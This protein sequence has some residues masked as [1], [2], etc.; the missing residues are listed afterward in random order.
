MSRRENENTFSNETGSSS[1]P[2]TEELATLRAWLRPTDYLGESSE[3]KKHLNSH[4]PGTGEWLQQTKQY[5]QWHDEAKCGALWVKAIAGAGKSVLAARLISHLQETEEQTPVLFFFFRQIVAAN[6]DAQSF[7]RDWMSQLVGYSPHLRTQINTWTKQHR[8]SRTFSFDEL[9]QCV[10]ESLG[11]LD[12]VYCVVDAMDELNRDQTDFLLRRLVDLGQI[13]PRAV[14][15]VMTS[16][17]LPQIQKVLNTPSVLQLRLEDRQTNKDI[18]L[19]IEYR[20]RQAPGISDATKE[21]IRTSIE[22]RVHPSFLYARLMLNE[23]MDQHKKETIDRASV[24]NALVSLPASMETMYS[25]MLHD[26]SQVAGVPQ[27]RQLLILQL[28]T[29]ASRPLRLLEIATVLDF[30][31]KNEDR[32]RHGDTKNMTRISCGPLLEILE[33]E[34]VSI[35]HHSFTEFLID[36]ERTV[37]D[38]AFPVIDPHK[39]NE[40]MT[41]ICV[42]YLLSG[43]LS[44]W[45]FIDPAPFEEEGPPTDIYNKLD[46]QAQR[47]ALQLQYPFLAYALTGWYY[48]ARK[49]PDLSE[50]VQTILKSLVNSDNQTFLAWI[51]AV[52]QPPYARESLSPFHIASWAGMTSALTAMLIPGQDL[53]GWTG[54]GQNALIMAA[55]QGHADTVARL[56]QLGA[57]PNEPDDTGFNALHYAAGRDHHATVQVLINASV[58]PITPTTKIRPKP[59]PLNDESLAGGTPLGEASR[60]GCVE[61]IRVM[62]PHLAEDDRKRSLRAAVY[63][64]RG[65][66]IKYLV[67]AA[68]LDLKSDF[69][70]DLMLDAASKLDLETIELLFSRG[71]DP[72]FQR[73]S[74][75][76]KSDRHNPYHSRLPKPSSLLF[77]LCHGARYPSRKY[78]PPGTVDKAFDFVFNSGCDI[79]SRDERGW[80][81]LHYC[82]SN[83]I[84]MVEKLLDRGGDVHAKDNNGSAPLHLYTSSTGTEQILTALLKYGATWGAVRHSDGQT[85]LHA[86]LPYLGETY[87]IEY[88]LPILTHWNVSDSKGNTVLHSVI[89]GGKWPNDRLK[90]LLDILKENGVDIN[91][92]N[93]NGQT[94]LHLVSNYKNEDTGRILVA[95]G[96]DIEARDYKGRTWWLHVVTEGNVNETD[97]QPI[98]DLGA[99]PNAVDDAGNNAL[100]LVYGDYPLED[101]TVE[102]LLDA[103]VDPLHVNRRGETIYHL[104]MRQLFGHSDYEVERAVRPLHN[105]KTPIAARDYQ[106]RTLLHIAC[107]H[108]SSI[109]SSRFSP[110]DLLS[111]FS[112]PEIR[113]MIRAADNHGRYPV[114]FAAMSSEIM[115]V[116]LIE[117]GA[118]ILVQTYKGKSPLHKAAA[119]GQS[120]VVGLLLEAYLER[121]ASAEINRRDYI[122]RTPLQYACRSGRLES[123]RLLL[124][125]GADV[126]MVDDNGCTPLHICAEF[127]I[128]IPLKI[129]EALELQYRAT[130]TN[131][132]HVSDIIR[133]LC[134]QG[135]DVTALNKAGKTPLQ[136][137][138]DSRAD[139]MIITL[140]G[141]PNVSDQEH[142]GGPGIVLS[143]YVEFLAR[144]RPAVSVV[145]EMIEKQLLGHDLLRTCEQ[146]HKVRAYDV[147]EEIADR[148]FTLNKQD[149]WT[150]RFLDTLARQE[151]VCLSQ[152]LGHSGDSIDQPKQ[153]A[154]LPDKQYPDLESFRLTV[155]A[156]KIRERPSGHGIGLHDLANGAHWWQPAAIRYLAQHGADV[157]EMNA[158]R[159]TPL[160]VAVR[161]DYRCLETVQ[162]LLELGADTN[163]LKNDG[164]TPLNLAVGDTRITR[165][166]LQHGADFGAG[167][168]PVYY[169]AVCAGDEDLVRAI[170]ETG[171]DPNK[172]FREDIPATYE[173]GNEVPIRQSGTSDRSLRSRPLYRAAISGASLD[174]DDE[175]KS[176]TDGVIKVLLEYGA[177]PLMPLDG[178]TTIIHYCLCH[179]AHV[180]P[181]LTVPGLNLE[182]RDGYGRTMLLAACAHGD[183]DELFDIRPAPS[184]IRLVRK[185]CDMGAEL[186][187]ADGEGNTAA[188]LLIHRHG[189]WA[190]KRMA[191]LIVDIIE[192]CPSL[193]SQK[194]NKGFTPFHLAVQCQQT[195]LIQRLLALGANAAEPDPEE[196][197][198][199][200][201]AAE[202]MFKLGEDNLHQALSLGHTI[203]ARNSAGETPIMKYISLGNTEGIQIF[204]NLGADIFAT[205]NAGETL[206]HVLARAPTDV[207]KRIPF[208]WGLYRTDGEK[209]VECFK[210]LLGLGLDPSWE[211]RGSRTAMDVAAA[212]GNRGILG[213]FQ[214]KA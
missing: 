116:W 129:L 85:P 153:L 135:A 207:H 113:T 22:G 114:H 204:Q 200:H 49:L 72:N 101:E 110:D 195:D 126:N 70:G 121:R 31:N 194:N 212:Y 181:L 127:D 32:T 179:R 165:L 35:I 38:G 42:R 98:L 77:A 201:Y 163:I 183:S 146:L 82:V 39:T 188:H 211:D 132:L 149:G 27:E 65:A 13:R 176:Q 71:A 184:R 155:A 168:P 161:A 67:N 17:P 169:S 41:I 97:L 28:V 193:L 196:N 157:N 26:H 73:K 150:S 190:L 25:Q 198:M 111:V 12:R 143:P 159:G 57:S 59:S 44:S 148:G 175:P 123:V 78:L 24:E 191:D 40:L 147:L 54:G 30:L 209:V 162:T 37:S 112:E 60:N 210:Y 185:L 152:K 167:N 154:L 170:L 96:A 202:A 16:R 174:E 10:L 47:N 138:L 178:D 120:D 8:V 115:V 56:I 136:L 99:N 3:F 90:V 69:G 203:N 130:E 182:H 89:G 88:I 206:L 68:D 52:K 186:S 105:R 9:W 18:S 34:T 139:E 156:R 33:D 205:N 117:N 84:F 14:K 81:A 145:D 134:Q 140:L 177:D 192:K 6:H 164:Y 103:G 109:S 2:S 108:C 55:T 197:T 119:A 15:V 213:L 75:S 80:T 23:L 106:G 141:M 173:A 93:L 86:C 48:H 20:L 79:N 199:V 124:E 187:V 160:H 63:F 61:S 142:L 102:L 43:P 107:M 151:F 87:E 92:R 125:A 62:L 131:G 208:P 51:D 158:N 171:V 46:I 83:N 74:S 118:D 64:G 58:S 122:G 94:P 144:H 50:E 91:S 21:T 66:L 172:P 19:F 133:L 180:Y 137:A 100:H 1:D 36:T 166:L 29:H 11:L 95:A 128:S 7:V 76:D 4:V 53:N 45:E 189:P 5:K 214:K 104:L